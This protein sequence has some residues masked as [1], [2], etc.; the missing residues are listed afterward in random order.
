MELD[1]RCEYGKEQAEQD[2]D[3]IKDIQHAEISPY[4]GIVY[5]GR[6]TGQGFY[7]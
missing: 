7:M 1:R 4:L 5:C 6:R 3:A 2:G